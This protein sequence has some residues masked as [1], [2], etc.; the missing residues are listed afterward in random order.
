[1]FIAKITTRYPEYHGKGYYN[2]VTSMHEDELNAK[3][4]DMS[5]DFRHVATIKTRHQ[6]SEGLHRAYPTKEQLNKRF[7]EEA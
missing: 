4:E 6:S 1:M 5:H 2:F 3:L 7:E